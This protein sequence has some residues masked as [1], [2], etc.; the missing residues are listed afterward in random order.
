[1]RI[2]VADL[3]KQLERQLAPM[4]LL[5][6]EEPLLLQESADE[7]RAACRTRGYAERRI[8][9]ADAGFDWN[10]CSPNAAACPCLPSTS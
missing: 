6:G 7:L 3:A 1:M 10:S 9:D 2:G 8:F 4:Y 5:Y